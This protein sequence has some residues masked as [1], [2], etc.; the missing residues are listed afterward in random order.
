MG[1]EASKRYRGKL[2][3]DKQTYRQFLAKERQ[4]IS[5]YRNNT[6]RPKSVN[7]INQLHMS[8]EVRQR[9]ESVNGVSIA[10]TN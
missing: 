1:K 10:N 4:R 8:R 2:K 3:Q 5:N 9:K 6:A 7:S